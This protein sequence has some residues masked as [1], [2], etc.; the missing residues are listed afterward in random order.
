MDGDS[1]LEA[2]LRDGTGELDRDFRRLWISVLARADLADLEAF[3]ARRGLPDHEVI[4]QPETG[5]VMIEGRA[6]GGGRRFNAGEATMTRCV[7]RVGDTL[8]FS[9]AL[10]RGKRKALLSAVY[11]A[12]L[13]D[14]ATRDELM[15]DLV[16]PLRGA[17]A[18]ARETASRKA[19][20]TKVEFFTMV[21]GD[22]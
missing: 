18:L 13:Q 5:T 8:G 12:M 20:A 19:A 4:R 1:R 7:A 9:Y 2:A 14:A 21:R 6:G 10:G 3:A 22:G 11:D 17:Q 15:R 16:E